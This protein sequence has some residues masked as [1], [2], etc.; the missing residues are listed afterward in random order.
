MRDYYSHTVCVTLCNT[1]ASYIKWILSFYT[2]S[3]N[4]EV[5]HSYFSL[6]ESVADS[7]VWTCTSIITGDRSS[8]RFSD[9]DEV[10]VCVCVCMC[11]CVRVCVHACMRVCACVYLTTRKVAR[12]CV[13]VGVHCLLKNWPVC[14]T[15]C[16]STWTLSLHAGSSLLMHVQGYLMNE[17]STSLI[18]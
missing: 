9:D 13:W 12:N 3:D 14:F 17:L 6:Q 10:S 7:A 5:Y 4:R 16:T 2:R 15:L 11:V 8:C 18:S 1:E